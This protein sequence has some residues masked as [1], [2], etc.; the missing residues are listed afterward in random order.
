MVTLLVTS[1]GLCPLPRNRGWNI[2]WGS[3]AGVVEQVDTGALKAPGYAVRVRSPPP[4]PIGRRGVVKGVLIRIALT[5]GALFGAFLVFAT[6]I[7]IERRPSP[8]LSMDA[9]NLALFGA[10]LPAA[11]VIWRRRGSVRR[12]LGAFGAGVGAAV[13]LMLV[14]VFLPVIWFQLTS[15]LV[16][17]MKIGGWTKSAIIMVPGIVTYWVQGKGSGARTKVQQLNS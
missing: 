2:P 1:L 3:A 4:A 16:T 13:A 15:D 6:I 7:N 11:L 5:L 8:A 9:G 14:A 10:F 17:S 12:K